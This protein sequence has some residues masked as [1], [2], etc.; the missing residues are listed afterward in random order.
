IRAELIARHGA[1]VV[2]RSLRRPL[3]AVGI[4]LAATAVIAL[5]ATRFVGTKPHEGDTLADGS[6][7]IT[8][9]GAKLTVLGPRHVRVEGA[10]LPAVVPGKGPFVVEP[11]RGRIEVLGTKFLVDGEA[12]RTIAAVVRGAV[13]LATSDGTLVLHAGEQGVAEAGHPPV[14][15]P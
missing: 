4:G 8:E 14:R 3:M 2:E 15:Q 6:T 1:P 5:I 7:Y 13:Q 11:A 9:P 10:A 12:A